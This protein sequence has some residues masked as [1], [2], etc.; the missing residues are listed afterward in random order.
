M[1]ETDETKL[2]GY[3]NPMLIDKS[4]HVFRVG[5]DHD[6]LKG[7]KG[8]AKEEKLVKMEKDFNAKFAFYLGNAMLKWQ[9]RQVIIAPYHF[10]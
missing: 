10:E 9:D 5:K 7:L 8:K 1:G 4:E 3:L 2:I 6:E